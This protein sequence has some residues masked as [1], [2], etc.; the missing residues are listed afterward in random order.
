MINDLPNIIVAI[1][2]SK[3]DMEYFF[4]LDSVEGYGGCDQIYD[5]KNNILYVKNDEEMI[6][7]INK[8]LEKSI[9]EE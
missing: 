4:D 3:Y 6:K 1:D 2:V 7:C 9:E 8:L 5:E